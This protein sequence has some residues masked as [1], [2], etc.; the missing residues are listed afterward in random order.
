M[1]DGDSGCG[2]RGN[3]DRDCG[4]PAIMGTYVCQTIHAAK[5]KSNQMSIYY[6]TTGLLKKN[7]R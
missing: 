7:T 6:L 5:R 4:I 1:G 2:N 3:G